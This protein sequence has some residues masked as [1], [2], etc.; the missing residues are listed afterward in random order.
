MSSHHRKTRLAEDDQFNQAQ[1]TV[2][3]VL[4]A[5]AAVAGLLRVVGVLN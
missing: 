3:A 4:V 5:I 2:F 1:T